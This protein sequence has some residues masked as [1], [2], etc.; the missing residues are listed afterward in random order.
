[1]ML[2]TSADFVAGLT[3]PADV[4]IVIRAEAD[5]DV[6]SDN[7]ADIAV[8]RSTTPSQHDQRRTH[9]RTPGQ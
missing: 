2:L 9:S 1:M 4:S 8:L 6:F 3:L 7:A 5:V